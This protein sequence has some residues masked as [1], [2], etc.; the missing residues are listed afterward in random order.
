MAIEKMYFIYFTYIDFIS[1]FSSNYNWIKMNFR[2]ENVFMQ[3]LKFFFLVIR[4]A[5]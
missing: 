3:Y 2:F 4:I 1:S 5:K